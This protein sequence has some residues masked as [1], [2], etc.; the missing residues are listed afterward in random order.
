MEVIHGVTDQKTPATRA[1]KKADFAD[2][3][4]TVGDL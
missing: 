3:P 2:W 1:G 4:D